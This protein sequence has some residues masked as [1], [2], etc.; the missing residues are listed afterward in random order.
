MAAMP[1]SPA[2]GTAVGRDRASAR[3]PGSFVGGRD[4]ADP[5]L[6][7][8]GGRRCAGIILVLMHCSAT[9]VFHVGG[10]EI[11]SSCPL[12]TQSY[13]RARARRYSPVTHIREA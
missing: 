7:G 11:G 5:M 9:V 2:T 8:G 6:G 10:T 1:A 13:E 3:L 4:T 12:D